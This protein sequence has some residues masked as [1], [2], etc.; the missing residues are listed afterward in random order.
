MSTIH[1]HSVNLWLE[2]QFVMNDGAKVHVLLHDNDSL[3]VEERAGV[4]FQKSINSLVLATLILRKDP[5]TSKDKSNQ[6]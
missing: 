3:M 6:N 2:G 4:F 5:L 1:S